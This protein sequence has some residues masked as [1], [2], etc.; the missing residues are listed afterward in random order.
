M[1]CRHMK[2]P[3]KNVEALEPRQMLAAYPVSVGSTAYDSAFKITK[4]ANDGV[5]VAGLF[6]GTIDLDPSS[7]QALFTAM[8]DTDIYVARYSEAGGLVWAR[9]FGGIE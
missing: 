3:A 5:L 1:L 2:N 9:Q 6:K 8:G 4:L 7:R